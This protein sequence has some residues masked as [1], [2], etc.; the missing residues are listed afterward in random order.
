MKSKIR[1][2]QIRGLDESISELA[3]YQFISITGG[4]YRSG[5]KVIGGLDCDEI[6]LNNIHSGDCG[7]YINEGDILISG[8]SEQTVSTV[9]NSNTYSIN[10]KSYP[11]L[12]LKKNDDSGQV[13]FFLNSD[14]GYPQ[15]GD[16]LGDFNIS[17]IG[18]MNFSIDGRTIASLS[19]TGLWSERNYFNKTSKEGTGFLLDRRS[20]LLDSFNVNQYRAATYIIFAS[21][22]STGN[23]G[24]GF[25]EYSVSVNNCGNIFGITG[26]SIRTDNRLIDISSIKVSDTIYVYLQKN[27]FEN[28]RINA[29]INKIQFTGRDIF[30]QEEVQALRRG[31]I[32]YWHLDDSFQSN[33]SIIGLDGTGIR[34]PSFTLGAVNNCCEFNGSKMIEIPESETE[35]IGETGSFSIGCWIKPLSSDEMY[36]M[37]KIEMDGEDISKTWA[38]LKKNNGRPA[39]FLYDADIGFNQT[40]GAAMDSNWNHILF[41]RSGERINVWQNGSLSA[42]GNLGGMDFPDSTGLKIFIGAPDE[43]SAGWSGYLDEVSIWSR[44]LSSS[45][46]YSLYKNGAGLSIKE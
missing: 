20:G 9:L 34:T 26:E 1:Q 24:P 32:A 4:R 37:G 2:E 42:T 46:V 10:K 7:I 38:I 40:T 23:Y 13:K 15:T 31:L 27:T 44:E 29:M 6:I 39:L 11:E 45:E 19:E 8:N 25:L 17:S 43:F 16:S 18:E 21:E 22:Y 33:G 28:W 35:L 41:S 12:L 14:D 36:V 5:I 3:D 30:M